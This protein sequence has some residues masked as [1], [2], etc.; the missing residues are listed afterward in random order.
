[1]AFT[2]CSGLLWKVWMIR[3][4]FRDIF[5]IFSFIFFSLS[6]RHLHDIDSIFVQQ[7]PLTLSFIFF[8]FLFFYSSFLNTN[9]IPF[10]F[11]DRSITLLVSRSIN[12]F[13]RFNAP[14]IFHFCFLLNEWCEWDW[15]IM[16]LG[17]DV[18]RKIEA[19]GSKSGKTSRRV[20]ILDCGQLP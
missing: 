7:R 20:A 8:S 14:S 11:F 15:S 6:F 9:L 3:W 13:S 16:C 10:E 2:W 5:L 17:V 1:M 18:V 12:H 4:H 19:A